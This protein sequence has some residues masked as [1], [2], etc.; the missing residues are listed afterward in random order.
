MV[1]TL[2]FEG[3]SLS[4]WRRK[5]LKNEWM[6]HTLEDEFKSKTTMWSRYATTRS[7]P[8]VTSLMIFTNQPGNTLQP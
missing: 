2:T 5:R 6:V 1:P 8:L 3:E 4:L 7:I